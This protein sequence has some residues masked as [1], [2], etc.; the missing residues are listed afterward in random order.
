MDVDSLLWSV[1]R[2]VFRLMLSNFPA[3]SENQRSLSD[4][5][6][7][8]TKSEYYFCESNSDTLK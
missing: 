6:R 1:R 3:Y 5:T 7:P 4:L 8:L 2:A